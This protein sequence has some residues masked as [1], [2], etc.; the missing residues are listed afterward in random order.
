M[1]KESLFKYL[2]RKFKDKYDKGGN[3]YALH[4]FSV[5][6]RFTDKYGSRDYDCVV[7]CLL[8]DILE[9]TDTTSSELP[10][11]IRDDVIVLTRRN[12]ETYF[13]YINRIKNSGSQKAIAVKIADLKDHLE[14]KDTLKDSLKDRY[15]KAL[16]ILEGEN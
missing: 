15:I 3:P 16:N 13:E 5:Q 10:M 12:D 1:E 4:L 9:D 2:E 7:T 8:H 11:D 14:Q 6:K